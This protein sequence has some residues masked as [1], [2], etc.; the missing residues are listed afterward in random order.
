MRT[1]LFSNYFNNSK[2]FLYSV[3]ITFPLVVIY[4]LCNFIDIYKSSSII[5]NSVDLLSLIVSYLNIEYPE[6]YKSIFI[7]CGYFLIIYFCKSKFNDNNVRIKYALIMICEGFLYS[8]VLYSLIINFSQIPLVISSQATSY[9]K[10]S[11][12]AGIW[13]EFVFRVILINIFIYIFSI[14]LK[15][16]RL[17]ILLSVFI[18]AILFSSFHFI[19]PISDDFII[20]SFLYRSIAGLYLGFLYVVRGYGIAVYCHMFYDLFL[21]IYPTY[22]VGV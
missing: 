8:L 5:I 21:L 14:I 3:I 19:G 20:N 4:Q 13:E 6:F 7:F 9:L 15:S 18:S 2:T 11:I 16:S 10:M 17:I 22:N 1:N 12:G